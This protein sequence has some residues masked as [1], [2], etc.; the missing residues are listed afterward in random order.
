M[1][2]TSWQGAVPWTNA[3]TDAYR[4]PGVFARGPAMQAGLFPISILAQKG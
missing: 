3:P 1:I 4:A 2:M